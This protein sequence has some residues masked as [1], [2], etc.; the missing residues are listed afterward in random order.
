MLLD[1]VQQRN[2]ILQCLHTLLDFT[3]C[4]QLIA[5]GRNR[6]LLA[7]WEHIIFD[8]LS[9]TV[10]HAKRNRTFFHGLETARIH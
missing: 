3:V 9:R 10:C 2:L 1:F 5:D 6:V 4:R 8:E 7:L